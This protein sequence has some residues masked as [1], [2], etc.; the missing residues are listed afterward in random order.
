VL[1]FVKQ[2]SWQVACTIG[3][4]PNHATA[5]GMRRKPRIIHI[6]WVHGCCCLRGKPRRKDGLLIEFLMDGVVIFF[7]FIFCL[8]EVVDCLTAI[9]FSANELKHR[10]T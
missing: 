5:S 6:A 1:L 2:A 4:S 7:V 10:V 9:Q 8:D 3:E